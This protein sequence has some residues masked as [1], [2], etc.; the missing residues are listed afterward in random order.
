M[1]W[2]EQQFLTDGVF[3]Q[4]LAVWKWIYYDMIKQT[5]IEEWSEESLILVIVIGLN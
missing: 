3:I 2:F 5:E 4:K 1:K